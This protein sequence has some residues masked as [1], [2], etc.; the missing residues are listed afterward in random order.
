MIMILTMPDRP[1]QVAQYAIYTN[2]LVA[3]LLACF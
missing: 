2:K 3:V 1:P